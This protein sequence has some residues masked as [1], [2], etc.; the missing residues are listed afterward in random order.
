MIRKL[1]RK[2]ILVNMLLVSIALLV[3]F[4]SV[5]VI[6]SRQLARESKTLMEQK[7]EPQPGERPSDGKTDQSGDNTPP[8]LPQGSQGEEQTQAGDSVPSSAEQ[9]GNNPGGRPFNLED[10]RESSVFLIQLDAN[11]DVEEIIGA[12]SLEIEEDEA[13]ELAQTCMETGKDSGILSSMGLRYMKRTDERGTR[14]VFMDR[15][16]ELTTMRRLAVILILVGMGSLLVFFL[17]SLWLARWVVGPVQRSWERERQFVADA[18]HELKT[19]LTVILANIGILQRHKEDTIEQQD[20]WVENTKEEAVRMKR[21]VEDMLELARADAGT[22]KL[23]ME[24]LNISDLAWSA[25]LGFESVV[26]EQ[27]KTLDTEIAPDMFINGDPEKL[28]QLLVILIDNACKY[29]EP[30]GAITVTLEPVKNQVKLTVHNTGSYIE[31]EMQE[32]LFERFYRGD[33]SRSREAGGYGLGLAIAKE[34]VSV[35]KGKISVRS[36]KETGTAFEVTIPG[37]KNG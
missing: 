3:T 34:I 25:A 22:G 5:M 12:D 14:L 17:I 4:S 36:E 1:K 28:K 18:S 29:S 19:P 15:S 9:N 37:E 7:L 31:K 11:G 26:F 32:H 33:A 23:H 8:D 20:K 30:G 16:D 35:H 2:F 24:K 10:P 6:N 21:L 13:K 27:K